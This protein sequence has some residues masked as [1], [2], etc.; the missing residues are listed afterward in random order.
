MHMPRA[1][2]AVSSETP[3]PRD[4]CPEGV[5]DAAGVQLTLSAADTDLGWM[6]NGLAICTQ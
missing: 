5:Q 3:V 6:K 1:T 4:G 2:L